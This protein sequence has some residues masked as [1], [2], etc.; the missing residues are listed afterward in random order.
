MLIERGIKELYFFK[1][2]HHSRSSLTT[3]PEIKNH[4]LGL[5]G[6]SQPGDLCSQI[7]KK[8]TGVAASR[9]AGTRTTFLIGVDYHHELEKKLFFGDFLPEI[10]PTNSPTATQLAS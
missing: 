2:D 5:S 4:F 10:G 8:N 6:F 9:Y 3:A 7:W 1:R